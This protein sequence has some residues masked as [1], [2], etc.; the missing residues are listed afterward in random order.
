MRFI[1]LVGGLALPL[2]ACDSGPKVDV[3]DANVG[4][5]AEAVAKSGVAGDNDFQVR[6]GKWQSQVTI[7]Q[8]DIPGM[9][10]RMQDEMKRSFAAHQP[11]AFT[12]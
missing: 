4:E 5:V 12:A 10:A 1:L 9:P 7:E 11:A 2:A 3:K 6:P 8:I